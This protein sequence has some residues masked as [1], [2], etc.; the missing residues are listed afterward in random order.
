MHFLLQFME[1]EGVRHLV[2][3]LLM[4]DNFQK[5]LLSQEKYD[6]MQAQTDAMVIYEK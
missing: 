5:H 3:F 4:A 2:D 6:G 1:Q